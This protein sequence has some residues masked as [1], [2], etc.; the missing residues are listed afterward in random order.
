MSLRHGECRCV[1][2]CVRAH[3]RAFISPF[4]ASV[5]GVVTFLG[6]FLFIFFLGCGNT[7]HKRVGACVS[8]LGFFFVL[9]LF[10]V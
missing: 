2:A 6:G 7:K 10:L 4:V 8:G 1:C 9:V 5:R 3:A